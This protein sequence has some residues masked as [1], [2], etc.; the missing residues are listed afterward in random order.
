V[1]PSS[2][3]SSSE[4]ETLRGRLEREPQLPVAEAVRIAVAIAR[5]L[6]QA[7]RSGTVHPDLTPE[8]IFLAKDP[9]GAPIRPILTVVGIGPALDA[10]AGNRLPEVGPGLGNPA[11][12]SP[13]QAAGGPADGRS[14]LYAL[15]C[16]TYEM[17]AG[18]PP[19]TGPSRQAILARHAADRPPPLRTVRA[20]VPQSI[21]SAIERALAK[22]PGDRFQTGDAFARA[23]TMEPSSRPFSR[24]LPDV[25]RLA[26]AAVLGV[27][28]GS[29]GIAYLR[30]SPARAVVPSAATI[31][32]L[33]FAAEEG[34]S[35]LARLG[36]DLAITVGVG[37]DGVGGLRVADRLGSAAETRD[38]AGLSLEEGAAVA[39]RL[40]ARS[41]L[42]GRLSAAGPLARLELG[43][44]DVANLELV[45]KGVTVRAHRDSIRALTDSAVWMLL[46][47]VWRRGEP[48][49]PSLAAV[50]TRSLPALRAFLDG[51]RELEAMRLEQAALA[52]RSAIAADS[53]F[54]LAH[55]RYALA[56]SWNESTVEPEVLQVVRMHRADF[57]EREQL[58]MAL[59]VDSMP[60][61]ERVG[62][63]R[64]VT[65]RFPEYWPGWL[66]YA[67]VLAH[68]GPFVGHDRTETVEALG[69]V[70]ALNPRVVAAWEHLF[71]LSLGRGYAAT[72][73]VATRLTE[74]GWAENERQM[75]RLWAG[76]DR[77]DG[78]I[79]PELDP[80]VDSLAEL[81]ALTPGEY[82]RRHGAFG[83]PLLH[84]GFTSAQLEL[85]RRA[86]RSGNVSVHPRR[87][88]Y[89]RT[90]SAYAWTAGGQWD[91]ALATLQEVV[92]EYSGVLGPKGFSIV[93]GLE[94]Y[95]LAVLA[96]WLGAIPPELADPR[97]PAADTA[98][99]SLTEDEGKSEW[100]A[101]L[102]WFDGLLAFTRK[103]G[104]AL[105]V[106]RKD[107]GQSGY[108]YAQR[109]E[110]SLGAFDRALSGD[111]AGAGRE[112]ATLEDHC[113]D[114]DDCDMFLF[115][116]HIGVHRLAAAQW[117][118]EAGD[119][120]RARRL[121]RWQD[122]YAF[123]GWRWTFHEVLAAPTYLARGRLEEAAGNREGAREHYQQFLMR[124]RQPIPSQAHLVEE[125][126]QALVRLQEPARP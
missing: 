51:E 99:A 22:R 59:L 102:A 82:H 21:A 57:P 16:L 83:F 94:N 107:A 111:R 30:R 17:L 52:F 119:G 93:A 35:A 61:T 55:Y 20:T 26:L 12:L 53:T 105:Q 2:S 126:R 48:P 50:T 62:R 45:G 122:I 63:A 14:D 86:L 7:H 67:D 108:V 28:L 95:G 123:G 87:R 19:F 96:A 41:V 66:A 47:Q 118:A 116:P 106:A 56:Q 54:W 78:A 10:A 27:L 74:L 109:V 6:D 125:A 33:P 98:V 8:N 38:L 43:L 42:R 60:L 49:S 36:R 24:L 97:R 104:K 101:R 70:V 23:L 37:L 100:L 18:S 11:Y 75:Y 1:R 44:H 72:P 84:Y 39:R 5:A 77:S 64:A 81:F 29:G 4:G 80:L 90:A 79:T 115:T 88:A 73:G 76:L 40:G 92:A 32:V 15:G 46:R 31:A 9:S 68:A 112:L 89:V 91:S 117:L 110:R 65:Q 71:K 34:D 120:E 3:A 85:N 25:P 58:L 13:E 124:Y 69:R 103:D 114:H 121:L 113:V